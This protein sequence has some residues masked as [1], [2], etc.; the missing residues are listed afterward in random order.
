VDS[1]NPDPVIR[2]A[3]SGDVPRIVELLAADQL[4][5]HRED[6]SLPL[7]PEYYAAF[8]AIAADPRTRLLVLE[9]QQRVVGTLQL[10]FLPGLSRRG[11]ER[12]HVE[13]VRIAPDMRGRGLGRLLMASAIEQARQQGCC[14]VQLTT[15][16]RREGAHRFYESMGFVHTHAGMK[17]SIEPN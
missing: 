2:V 8:D 17:R 15:D 11:A 9:V 14:L 12:A 5:T 3:Q 6:A 4:G 1:A 10:N 7:A 13:A 16:L